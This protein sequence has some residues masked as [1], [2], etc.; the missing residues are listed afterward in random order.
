MHAVVSNSGTSEGLRHTRA[1]TATPMRGIFG[2]WGWRWLAGDGLK[3]QTSFSLQPTGAARALES[4][5]LAR[6]KREAA[7]AATAEVANE[8]DAALEEFGLPGDTDPYPRE[9][10]LASL[11]HPL[12]I[13]C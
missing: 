2:E 10:V 12:I 1:G 5:E 11:G 3:C 8:L 4:E 7:N 6:L 13:L 9:Y